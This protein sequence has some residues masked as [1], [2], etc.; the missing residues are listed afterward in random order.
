LIDA[1]GLLA[2]YL[3]NRLALSHL[4]TSTL[5]RIKDACSRAQ[6]SADKPDLD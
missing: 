2:P 6:R 4:S 3:P 1:V 5:Q